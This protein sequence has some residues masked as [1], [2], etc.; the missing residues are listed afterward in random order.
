MKAFLTKM[1]AAS[2]L[3]TAW[4]TA[5]PVI[6]F[7]AARNPAPVPIA[8]Q[9]MVA[10]ASGSTARLTGHATGTVLGVT[11]QRGSAKP[12]PKVTVR[13]RVGGAWSAWTVLEM[14]DLVGESEVSSGRRKGAPPVRDGTEPIVTIGMT[15][16][17]VAVTSATHV[18]KG[19]KVVVVDSSATTSLVNTPPSSAVA[20]GTQPPINSRA[21]WGADESKRNCTPTYMSSIKAVGVHH[22][23]GTNSYT[24]EQ[25]PS[26]VNG[27][28][29][30]HTGANG[31]CD[32][33]YN[34]LVDR[35]G[36]LWEGRY[37]GLDRNVRPAAQGGFNY[38]TSSISAIGN[39]DTVAAPSGM[40]EAISRF[41]SWRLGLAHVDPLGSVSMTADY[42]STKYPQGSVVRV[43]TVFGHRNTSLT[44]CPGNNL[45]AALG[46]IRSE[47]RAAS[48]SAAIFDPSLNYWRMSTSDIPAFKINGSTASAQKVTVTVTSSATGKVVY[49]DT[50]SSLG[51]RFSALW[52]KR[53]ASGT[54]VPPGYYVMRVTSTSSTSSAL[55]YSRTVLVF[56]TA[57][58]PGD[59]PPEHPV[60][61]T[62]GVLYTSTHEW[63]T[64]CGPYS[65]ATR[66]Y[67]E[68]FTGG[69]W[70]R[71][72]WA[73]TDQGNTSWAGNRLA[74]T[75]GWSDGVHAYSTNCSPIV[76][77]G[78]R[79]CR[80]VVWNGTTRMW[81]I[82]SIVWLGDGR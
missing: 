28:Y 75:G 53:D 65:T 13:Y 39:F 80:T 9:P 22:T 11:W 59:P 43:G 50:T 18:P 68:I 61:R 82:D 25:V 14:A 74:V 42:G 45:Y 57:A 69:A 66:C 40:I 12:P 34:V 70:K 7:G 46:T 48:G 38:Y 10:D 24:P 5:A 30:Y 73:Y 62:P 20:E 23:A 26:I 47:A 67:V 76:T 2:V 64:S 79:S 44:S 33:G 81:V 15:D 36:R 72:N 32:I 41:I 77:T 4:Q 1:L 54:I 3:V 19:L 63:R 37:G 31:W 52:D 27:I 29:N 16:Y 6:T 78:A 51:G 58:L 49:T 55:P 17:E 8:A 21:S 60:N 56:G 71:N 35:F